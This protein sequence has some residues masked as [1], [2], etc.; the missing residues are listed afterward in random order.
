[1]KKYSYIDD[2][3]I[4]VLPSRFISVFDLKK[5]NKGCHSFYLQI[6]TQGLGTNH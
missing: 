4:T 1:M 5:T 2:V 3:A 6:L